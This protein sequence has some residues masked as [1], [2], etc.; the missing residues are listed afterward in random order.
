M[1]LHN[2]SK[3]LASNLTKKNIHN[4]N[5]TLPKQNSFNFLLYGTNRAFKD[6]AEKDKVWENV[7]DEFQAI[8]LQYLW[9]F[10]SSFMVPSANVFIMQLFS[11][12]PSF[13]S[14]LTES[15]PFCS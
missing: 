14:L 6:E 7:V 10:I 11:S 3:E 4:W 9:H 2:D 12:C 8:F 13:P 15:L 1:H 5:Y